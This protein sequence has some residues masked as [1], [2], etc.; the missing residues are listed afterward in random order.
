MSPLT[1]RLMN[2]ALSKRMEKAAKWY[3]A[4]TRKPGIAAGDAWKSLNKLLKTEARVNTPVNLG[5]AMRLPQF[6]AV[7]QPLIHGMRDF[8]TPAGQAL[9]ESV[10]AR[11]AN[12][13]IKQ[14]FSPQEGGLIT[15]LRS[16]IRNPKDAYKG[17]TGSTGGK[18]R[19]QKPG[20]LYHGE[21]GKTLHALPT[22]P[23]SAG[24][25]SELLE[26]LQEL[27]KNPDLAGFGAFNPQAFGQ[28]IQA[29]ARRLGRPGLD[30]AK[31]NSVFDAL[32]KLNI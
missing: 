12:P 27:M 7:R 10:L 9:T 26:R 21:L 14:F 18:I 13:G 22:A 24:A 3:G 25:R 11:A 19:L 4:A 31:S 17:I 23:G 1:S 16:F 2:L 30:A 5:S 15:W 20:L 8:A 28:N 32:A 29:V 6:S